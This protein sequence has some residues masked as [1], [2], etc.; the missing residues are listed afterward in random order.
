MLSNLLLLST[1]TGAVVSTICKADD[2]KMVG[3]TWEI[4]QVATSTKYLAGEGAVENTEATNKC[5]VIGNNPY[6]LNVPFKMKQVSTISPTV[7]GT[8]VFGKVSEADVTLLSNCTFKI[9]PWNMEFNDT[10]AE[11]GLKIY[12]LKDVTT[13]SAF[14]IT[15]ATAPLTNST[16]ETFTLSNTNPGFDGTSDGISYRMM[17]RMILYSETYKWTIAYADFPPTNAAVNL[18][19]I[20]KITGNVTVVDGCSFELTNLKLSD[21]PASA[22]FTFAADLGNGS[23]GRIVN[24]NEYLSGTYDGTQV[25]GPVFNLTRTENVGKSGELLGVSW[26]EIKGMSIYAE[27][28]NFV[29]ATVTFPT[30]A[31]PSATESEDVSPTDSGSLG[32]SFL[33]FGALIF[34]VAAALIVA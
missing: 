1:F 19:I 27:I 22:K 18:T 6:P 4:I 10:T 21:A 14:P 26:D 2:D 5:S 9:A 17:K 13:T 11:L 15:N 30:K 28:N 32:N 34:A 7:N 33:S 8:A 23:N 31:K 29:L 24:N 25:K 20:P 3:K 16:T 12:G